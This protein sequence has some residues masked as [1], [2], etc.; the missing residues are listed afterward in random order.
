MGM[1]EFLYGLLYRSH[2]SNRS[3][4]PNNIHGFRI[5][6]DKIKVSENTKKTIDEAM[7]EMLKIKSRAGNEIRFS[8]LVYDKVPVIDEENNGLTYGYVPVLKRRDGT[9]DI[10]EHINRFRHFDVNNLPLIEVAR[11]LNITVEK[12]ETL[13]PY[14]MFIPTENRIVM[15][16][17][18]ASTFIHELVHAIDFMLGTYTND[19]NLDEVVTEFTTMVICM[20][21][22]IETDFHASMYYIDGYFDKSNFRI[23]EFLKRVWLI[24]ECLQEIRRDILSQCPR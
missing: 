5:S 1:S 9:V 19:K 16:S 17:D 23:D 3:N 8:N 6:A 2:V 14:G 21:Y 10:N 15:G 12:R 18:N 22:G 24:Y 20:S 13:E 11:H 4:L 7:S